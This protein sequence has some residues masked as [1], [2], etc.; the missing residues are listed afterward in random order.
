MR[1]DLYLVDNGYIKSRELA[2]L[3]IEKE[4]VKIDVFQKILNITRKY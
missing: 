1:L 2:K 4:L 3:A